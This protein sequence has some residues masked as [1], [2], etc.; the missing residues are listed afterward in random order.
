MALDLL[1]DMRSVVL[2]SAQP[3]QRGLRNRREGSQIRDGRRSPRKAFGTHKPHC[4]MGSYGFVTGCSRNL[5]EC[6]A[7]S[8]SGTFP[9]AIP[10]QS[11]RSL[12]LRP[13]L[14]D[15]GLYSAKR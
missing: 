11:R 5:I 9:T 8:P 7:N 15:P 3:L 1:I 13:F 10:V 6:W 12:L 4:I 2:K 14:W